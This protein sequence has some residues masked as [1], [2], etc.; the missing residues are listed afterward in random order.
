MGGHPT[1]FSVHTPG[2]RMLISELST[3]KKQTMPNFAVS[4]PL[5]SMGRR[6][7][8]IEHDVGSIRRDS[9]RLRFLTAGAPGGGVSGRA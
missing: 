2:R 9:E 8:K 4:L 3:V 7:Y 6:I 5:A 1:E